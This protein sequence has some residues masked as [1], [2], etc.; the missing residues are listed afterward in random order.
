[1][2]YRFPFLLCLSLWATNV[3][4]AETVAV[5][6]TY[7]G[8]HNTDF[9]S[10]SRSLK[11]AEF[12][13]NRGG[14]AKHIAGDYEA[15]SPL[16]QIVRDALIQGFTHGQAKLVEADED[17]QIAGNIVSSD[18]QTVDR[19]GVESLQLTVR[20]NVQLQG[21]GRTIWETTLFGRGV[22]PSTEGIDAALSAALDRMVRELV[23]DDYFLIE[24]Q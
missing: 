21:R 5:N 11:I 1:M 13:D 2:N 23:N 9:S 7:A 10:F 24:I 8:N 15:N 14:D 6:Y 16:A 22:V 19:S 3:L 4:A 18:L 12:G 17:M 20:F